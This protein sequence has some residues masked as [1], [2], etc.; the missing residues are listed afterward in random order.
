MRFR[1]LASFA[2]AAGSIAAAAGVP[3]I[4]R[5]SAPVDWVFSSMSVSG[6]AAAKQASSGGSV[7][8]GGPGGGSAASLVV[9]GRGH[10]TGAGP[11]LLGFAGG[12]GDGGYRVDVFDLADGGIRL[13]TTID[14]GGLDIEITPVG[15]DGFAIASGVGGLGAYMS[16]AVFVANAVLDEYSVQGEGGTPVVHA[17][18]GTQAISAAGPAASGV[19][20]DASLAAAGASSFAA[21]IPAGIIGGV[22]DLGCTR[23]TVTW[24]TPNGKSGSVTQ[25][26][27]PF[28]PVPVPVPVPIPVGSIDGETSFAGPAGAWSWTWT[29]VNVST[30]RSPTMVGAYAPIGDLWQ[31]LAGV[32]LPPPTTIVAGKPPSPKPSPRVLGSKQTKGT[33]ASTGVTPLAW[34]W[35]LLA[36]AAFA[37]RRLTV[38]R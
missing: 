11:I 36:A 16:S 38:T 19:A 26:S 1:R 14:L 6:G 22:V 30:N 32:H 18:A 7:S 12:F 25:T 34:G 35:L 20:V 23:C 10:G 28:V 9:S 2:I 5:A 37:G 27:L 17:G 4:G 31:D 8:I 3:G 13:R 21:A 15:K 29:G 33:L 24:A